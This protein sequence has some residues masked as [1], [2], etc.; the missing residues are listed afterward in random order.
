[1]RSSGSE[2]LF[3][4]AMLVSP[5]FLLKFYYPSPWTNFIL[6]I[7]VAAL[8]WSYVRHGLNKL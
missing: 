1:M 2:D 4:T 7:A 5:A 3:I 8:F 6:L